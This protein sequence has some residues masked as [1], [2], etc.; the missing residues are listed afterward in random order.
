M[1]LGAYRVTGS[2]GLLSDGLESVVNLVAATLALGM[3]WWA[4]QPADEGHPFGHAKAEYF[5]S[6]VEGALIVLAAVGIGS[7]ALPRLLAP[8]PLES[9]GLGLALAGGASL[10]NLGV[11]L[12]L[13]KAGKKHNSI[14]LEA[15]AHHLLTDVWTSVGVLGGIVLV[16]LTGWLWLD[17]ALALAVAF[18]IVWTG[19]QL[20]KRST[21]GLMDAA[22]PRVEQ[23]AIEQVLEG[24][25]QQGI[26]FHALRTRRAGT[27]SFV[28]LHVLVPGS[29]TVQRGHELLEQV[30]RD[31]REV[32][33]TRV[34]VLTHL[35]PLEDPASFT[36]EQL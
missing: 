4:E 25:R 5:S 33:P 8:Q 11:A 13:L 24:Y 7:A 2:V 26:D 20:V 3:L 30:E 27:R 21:Q 36:D 1:K 32:S 31:L 16:W 23:E 10:I 34:S 22:I 6:G 12:F 17:P 15:D 14:A 18:H 35:E 9:L 19:V 28:S 29:W